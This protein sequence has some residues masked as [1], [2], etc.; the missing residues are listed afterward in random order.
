MLLCAVKHIELFTLL[1]EKPL[2]VAE[3]FLIMSGSQIFSGLQLDALSSTQLAVPL[4]P[5]PEYLRVGGVGH[6]F[7]VTVYRLGL[8]VPV[9]V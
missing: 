8:V 5:V 6:V 4:P 9:C 1:G 7:S 2:P 3:R